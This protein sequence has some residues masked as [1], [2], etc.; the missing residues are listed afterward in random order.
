MT[1]LRS[2]GG[3]PQTKALG[4]MPQAKALGGMPQESIE[5]PGQYVPGKESPDSN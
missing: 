2:L 5:S 1:K 4:G 3:M